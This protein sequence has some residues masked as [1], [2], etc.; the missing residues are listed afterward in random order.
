MNFTLCVVLVYNENGSVQT[1]TTNI[2]SL[3]GGMTIN[4]EANSL[5]S[6]GLI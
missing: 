1:P 3:V 5:D 4:L 2:Y 6:Y